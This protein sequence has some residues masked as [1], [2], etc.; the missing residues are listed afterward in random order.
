MLYDEEKYKLETINNSIYLQLK[1][2][3]GMKLFFFCIDIGVQNRRLLNRGFG[4]VENPRL[5][6]TRQNTLTLLKSM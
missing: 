6:G 4:Y 5:N 3:C 1:T 2:S